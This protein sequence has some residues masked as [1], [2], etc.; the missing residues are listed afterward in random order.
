MEKKTYKKDVGI[1]YVN[2]YKGK[3]GKEVKY[4]KLML[5]VEQLREVTIENG[6]IALT[7]FFQTEKK[8]DKA[9]DMVF[10]PTSKSKKEEA[11]KDDLPF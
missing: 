10:K 11:K 6:Q 9:P 4:L 1:A 5:N 3:D 2:K 7:G 8:N